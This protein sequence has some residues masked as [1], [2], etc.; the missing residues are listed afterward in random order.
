MKVQHGDAC[1]SLQQMYEW[2]GKFMNGIS[3]VTL[4]PR[5]CQAQPV[6][7]PEGS[8]AVEDV[9]KENRRVTV[10]ETDAHLDMNCGSPYRP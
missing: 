6:V 10:S 8:T 5:P 2:T 4:S 1:V 9:V 7:T 3:F